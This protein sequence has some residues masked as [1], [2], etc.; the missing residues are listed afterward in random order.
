MLF[1]GIKPVLKTII[2]INMYEPLKQICD[3]NGLY[4][5]KSDFK[6]VIDPMR[7]MFFRIPFSDNRSDR[8]MVYVSKSKDMAEEVCSSELNGNTE[9]IGRLLGYPK[10]CVNHYMAMTKKFEETKNAIYQDRILQTYLNTKG[11]ASFYLNNLHHKEMFYLV[12]HFPCSYNCKYSVALAKKTLNILESEDAV[13]ANDILLRLKLPAL[14]S[15]YSTLFFEGLCFRNNKILYSQVYES[16]REGIESVFDLD[17][18]KTGNIVEIKE[19]AINIF[20]DEKL[21]NKVTGLKDFVLFN[22]KSEKEKNMV[23]G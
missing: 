13:L 15:N 8:I 6:V 21:L 3:C 19:K 1:A 11:D 14:Y 22:F 9:S 20:N 5:R 4:I 2:T 7:D 17:M 12:S 18:F 10:C 23:A 16:T